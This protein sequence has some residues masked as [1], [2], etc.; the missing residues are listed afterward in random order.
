MD[1]VES[2][3]VTHA[4]TANGFD[5]SEDGTGRGTPIIPTVA[6]TIGQR[7]RGQDD[8]CANNLVPVAM[9]FTERTRKDGRNLEAQDGLAYCLTNPGSGGRTHSR[10]LLHGT[11]V[12]RLTPR[13]CE[14]LQG[15]PDDWT[16]YR[17]DGEPIADGPRYRMLG[18]AVA[19]PVAAWLGERIVT[20]LL[21]A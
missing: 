3:V 12:R 5:A 18:N 9:A 8:S 11:A 20:A 6:A 17:D 7:M 1:T 14:R 16:A 15:F 10:Q 19:V 21:G 2:L 13:E 4:L